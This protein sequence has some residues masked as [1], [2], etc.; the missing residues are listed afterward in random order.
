MLEAL[1]PGLTSK[2]NERLFVFF[3]IFQ[4]QSPQRFFPVLE[5]TASCKIGLINS[6]TPH[7]IY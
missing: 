7:F 1:Q 5:T 2:L 3:E 4:H 6:L